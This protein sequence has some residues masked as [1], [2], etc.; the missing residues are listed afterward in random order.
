MYQR[1]YYP[2]GEIKIPENYGGYALTEERTEEI[3][4]T[5]KQVYEPPC[6][7]R[8][9]PPTEEE[10]AEKEDAYTP[11]FGEHSWE[12]EKARMEEPT[13]CLPVRRQRRDSLFGGVFSVFERFGLHMPS[14][15]FEDLLLIGV[16]ISLLLSKERDIECG[17]LLLALVF[18]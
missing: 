3:E 16:G 14:F 10:S 13:Q 8:C 1:K 9:D 11:I 17:L 6:E 12:R 4:D 5:P 15:D 7:K 18:L 2:Q